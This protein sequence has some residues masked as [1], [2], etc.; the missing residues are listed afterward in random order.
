MDLFQTYYKNN[1]L[2]LINLISSLQE[3]FQLQ[4]MLTFELEIEAIKFLSQF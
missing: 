4:L 1:C 2:C 3:T